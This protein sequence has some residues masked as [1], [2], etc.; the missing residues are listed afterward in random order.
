M[1]I[2]SSIFILLALIASSIFATDYSEKIN[3]TLPQIQVLEKET[4]TVNDQDI[5][6]E[7]LAFI[8]ADD[9]N[10]YY[11]G[12]V[13]FKNP[14]EPILIWEGTQIQFNFSGTRLGLRF[15]NSNSQTSY[16]N[17]IVDGKIYLLHME[18]GGEYDYFLDKKLD[19]G[20]HTC[21]VFKRN[22]AG[23]LDTFVGI[24]VDSKGYKKATGV[25]TMPELLPIKI[26]FYGDS[27]TAG[28]CDETVGDDSYEQDKMVTHNCYTSYP[29]I[30]CRMLNAELADYAVGG[31]GVCY[32]WNPFI[33][34][35]SWKKTYSGNLSRDFDFTTARTPD[36]VVINLGQNDFGL[37]DQKGG[38]PKN[39]QQKYTAF[40][41]EIRAQYP[42]AW[43]I[44][45]TG[46]MSAIKSSRELAS[47]IL[48]SVKELSATDTKILQFTYRAFTYSHP[49][50]DTHL[51]MA[52]QLVKFI[53]ANVL[54]E[55]STTIR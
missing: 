37:Q 9:K 15:K 51:L 45:A 30:A 11:T 24:D 6:D 48:N 31:T 46:G 27:I 52:Q 26:E 4:F 12:R 47:G 42:D 41:K 34:T 1:K 3:K 5:D 54:T 22:E 18:T 39:F 43:I 38:F 49:R 2:K 36:I 50:V 44:C 13:D 28:V 20:D 35:D 33:I 19:S 16:Y 8:S 10:I 40:L 23:M 32:S 7:T 53:Q 17:V 29:A 14:S 25:I 55:D 21:T